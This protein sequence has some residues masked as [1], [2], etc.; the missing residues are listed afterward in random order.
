MKSRP[1]RGIL[2]DLDGTI[3]RGNVL[4][5]GAMAVFDDLSKKG[6]KWVFHSNNAGCAAADLALRL[7]RMGLAVNENQVVN[8]A[9]ALIAALSR[10]PAGARVMVVGQ[11][12]LVQKLE[13][14]GVNVVNDSRNVDI[15]VTAID[16]GF[17]YHKL[18]EAQAALHNGAR[19][20]ATNLDASYPGEGAFLPG[21]GSIVAAISTAAGRGPERVLGKPSPD[22]AHIALELLGLPAESCIVVG[23]RM[24]SDILFA[25]NSGIAAALVLTGASSRNDLPG[26]SY[27]PDY[28]F[29]GIS[30]IATLFD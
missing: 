10:E 23:D 6:I 19:F 25:R 14:S 13:A 30:E 27:A 20:W 8:S 2:S 12:K 9:S 3:N 26:F 16:S 4:I 24:E 17:N 15:L 1:Y 18:K 22:M 7:N 5:P 28:V 21:A 29:S 11:E